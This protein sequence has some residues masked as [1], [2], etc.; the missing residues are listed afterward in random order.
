MDAH[1]LFISDESLRQGMDQ[2]TAWLDEQIEAHLQ[3]V[4]HF[5]DQKAI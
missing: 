2:Y 5:V 4:G 1:H 3:S